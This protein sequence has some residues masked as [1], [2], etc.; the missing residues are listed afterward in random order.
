MINNKEMKSDGVKHTSS[1]AILCKIWDYLDDKKVVGLR[2]GNE[3]KEKGRRKKKKK[4]GKGK[5]NFKRKKK[6]KKD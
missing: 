1:S 6:K 2:I 3:E 4:R 5:K